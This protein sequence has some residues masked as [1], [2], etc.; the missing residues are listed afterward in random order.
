[1]AATWEVPDSAKTVPESFNIYQATVAIIAIFLGFIFSALL[2]FLTSPG[3][4]AQPVV[5]GLLGGLVALMTALLLNQLTAHEVYT[6]FG[7]FFPRS[8]MA[9]IAGLFLSLGVFFMFLTVSALLYER[10]MK[11]RAFG[12]AIYGL[13]LIAF[14]QIARGR[15]RRTSAKNDANSAD[16]GPPVSVLSTDVGESGMEVGGWRLELRSNIRTVAQFREFYPPLCIGANQIQEIEAAIAE[17]GINIPRQYLTDLIKSANEEKQLAQIRKMVT[18]AAE[19][20]LENSTPDGLVFIQ[21]GDTDRNPVRGLTQLYPDRVLMS[22]IHHCM[23]N[24]QWCYRTK[25]EGGTLSESELAE[26]YQYIRRNS[27]ISDVIITGGEPLLASDEALARIL[28]EL[29]KID[30]VDI[31]RFHTRAPVVLPSRI[32]ESL[33]RTLKQY[34]PRGRPIYVVTHFVHPLELREASTEAIHKL[35][36]IGIP[37]FNQAPVLKGANDDQETFDDWNKRMIRFKVKPYYVASPVIKAG[38]NSRFSVPLADVKALLRNYGKACDGLGRPTLVI[39]VMGAK[40][41]SEEL[42]EMMA[43][44][45]S[46]IRRT[47]IEIT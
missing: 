39:P 30:H 26:V 37:V 42:E 43:S 44:K 14:F 40:C 38:V 9:L 17:Y 11:Y 16:H 21:A 10:G 41:T 33:I 31:I 47:K 45:E 36:D 28:E 34:S 1:M 13:A 32:D 8:P 29:R 20:R 19:S 6:T 15:L 5:W 3:T 23:M 22:P 35:L 25:E 18:P 12:L 46:H 7:I 2:S 27:R 4:L 24:C